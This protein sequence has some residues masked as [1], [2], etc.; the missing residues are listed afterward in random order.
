MR[1]LVALLLIAMSSRAVALSCFVP[2]VEER[3]RQTR[4]VMLVEVMR[5]RLERNESC[6]TPIPGR[7]D[8]I[9]IT[10]K[11]IVGDCSRSIVAGVRLVESYKGDS[12]PLELVVTTWAQN[13]TLTVGATYLVFADDANVTEDCEGMQLISSDP[14]QL[15]L[16]AKLRALAKRD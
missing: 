5:A 10:D 6:P 2:P 15:E 8:E 16:L 11:R 9:V 1:T 4:Y 14:A 12:P 13:P 3:F 7:E